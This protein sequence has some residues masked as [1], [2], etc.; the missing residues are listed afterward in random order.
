MNKLVIRKSI[1][2]LLISMMIISSIPLSFANEAAIFEVKYV[3]S[4]EGEIPITVD[5]PLIEFNDENDVLLSDFI[6]VKTDGESKSYYNI[7]SI[8]GEGSEDI[9]RYRDLSVGKNTLYAFGEELEG[10]VE[11][12]ITRLPEK[13][14]NDTINRSQTVGEDL[15]NKSVEEG[16]AYFYL[17][18]MKGDGGF[19]KSNEGITYSLKEEVELKSSESELLLEKTSDLEKGSHTIIAKKDGYETLEFDLIVNPI[20]LESLEIGV[21]TLVD[22]L[23]IFVAK[24]EIELFVGDGYDED[25]SLETLCLKTDKGVII[26]DFEL[27]KVEV[28]ENAIDYNSNLEITDQTIKSIAGGIVTLTTTTGNFTNTVTIIMKEKRKVN[29]E[30]DSELIIEAELPSVKFTYGEEHWL[31]EKTLIKAYINAPDNSKI[32][33]DLTLR[34]T[35]FGDILKNTSSLKAKNYVVDVTYKKELSSDYLEIIDE[36][37]NFRMIIEGEVEEFAEIVYDNSTYIEK[38]GLVATSEGIIYLTEEDAELEV[39]TEKDGEVVYLNASKVFFDTSETG[40]KTY[41]YRLK[42]DTAVQNFERVIEVVESNLD[43]VSIFIVKNERN[44]E[45]FWRGDSSGRRIVYYNHNTNREIIVSELLHAS[46]NFDLDYLDDVT[47]IALDINDEIFMRNQDTL[48]SYNVKLMT[49]YEWSTGIVSPLE[50]DPNENKSTGLAFDIDNYLY[51][52]EGNKVLKNQ[53]TYATKKIELVET[54]E[55]SEDYFIADIAFDEDG[56]FYMASYKEVEIEDSNDVEYINRLTKYQLGEEVVLQS[57]IILNQTDLKVTGINVF[58]NKLILAYDY[59]KTGMDEDSSVLKSIDSS[60]SEQSMQKIVRDEFS[61]SV[62]QIKDSASRF[63]SKLSANDLSLHIGYGQAESSSQSYISTNFTP[64]LRADQNRAYDLVSGSDVFDLSENALVKA[65]KAGSGQ[66]RITANGVSVLINISVTNHSAP[67]YNAPTPV[68]LKITPNP[69]EVEYGDGAD[70]ELLSK[71]VTYKL[72]GSNSKVTWKIEDETIA[73]VDSDGVVTGLKAGETTLTAKVSGA[74]T[75]AKVNVYFVDLEKDPLALVEF[76]Y[77]YISGYPNNTFAPNKAVT[78][79]ELATMFSKILNL[80]TNEFS[81]MTYSDVRS[82]NWS[83]GFIESVS[84]AGIFTGYKDGTFKPDQAVTR[85]EFAS[86]IAKYWQYFEVEVDKSSSIII[87]VA[88]DHWAKE[89]I[90]MVYN[91]GIVE[92]FSDGTFRPSEATLRAQIVV[93]I[94]ILIGREVTPNSL[95]NYDDVE[96]SMSSSDDINAAST[97][98]IKKEE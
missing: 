53:L 14:I 87:D 33:G 9:R 2:F 34:Y 29:Y 98:V 62:H 8:P 25:L 61:Y 18:E 71:K 42:T 1:V 44:L 97:S 7:N 32:Y 36:G 31:D 52:V 73:S 93:M 39:E 75:T 64:T 16:L 66:V 74:T 47:Q 57:E 54:F 48:Y 58:E 43:D 84:K 89:Y 56:N 37:Y 4:S 46:L 21:M 79:G 15:I 70:P 83:Y 77:A 40:T 3:I 38:K 85:A 60:L 88:N 90:Y 23:L 63:R 35:L 6:I 13:K 20:K 28:A 86:T 65:K 51:L 24:E 78:R 49:S 30:L 26:T 92:N 41:K 27:T 5:I 19:L 81:K 69:I 95:T 50:M 45:D 91:A 10:P 76:D 67:S 17:D 55:F 72:S 22:D 96:D 12:T 82:S 94:N 80:D 59:Q 11:F 68:S